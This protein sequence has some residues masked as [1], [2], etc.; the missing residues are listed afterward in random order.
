MKQRLR[1]G[2]TLIELLVVIAIIGVLI[3]LLLPAV[4]QAREAARR[5]T[6][7]NNLKQIA[8]AMANYHDSYNVYP[9]DGLRAGRNQ[10]SGNPEGGDANGGNYFSM[11]V[12]LL[13]F[14]D[15]SALYDSFNQS[16]G[17]VYWIDYYNTVGAY[18][19]DPQSATLGQDPQK[20]ARSTIVKTYM[21]PSDVSNPGNYERQAHG[22]SY[23]ANA[24]QLRNFRNWFSNGVSYQPGWDGALATPVS[25]NHILDGTSKTAAFGEFVKGPAIDNFNRAIDDPVAWVW[26]LPSGY[27]PDPGANGAILSQGFGDPVAGT[28]DA[29]FNVQCNKSTSPNWAWKGE[30]WVVGHAGRG[31]GLGFSVKPNGR[32]CYGAGSDP[33]DGGMASS[34]RHAGGVNLAMLDGSVQFVSEAIDFKVWWAKGSRAGSESAS[35][36]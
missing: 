11:Q 28:G 34:S 18:A 4:Q 3:A 9:P 22:H 24:G 26:N 35:N 8:L 14:L 29:Y 5:N 23:A 20:T 16:R 6:C 13:P 19:W 2:F 36:Q 10:W 25:I 17:A 15:Q 1:R 12:H 21:C 32:S 27:N 30:Y 31:S 33:S 7:V